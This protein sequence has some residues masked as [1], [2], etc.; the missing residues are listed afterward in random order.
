MKEEC[1]LSK[2]KA[3]KKPLRIKTEKASHNAA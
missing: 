2:M 1:D 3:Q